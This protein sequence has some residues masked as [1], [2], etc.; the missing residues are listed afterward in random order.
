MLP[1]RW[2]LPPFDMP[3]PLNLSESYAYHSRASRVIAGGVNSNVRLPGHGA[4]LCFAKAQGAHLTDLDGNDYIDYALGMGPAILGHAPEAVIDAVAKSLQGGQLYA[5]QSKAE[6]ELGNRLRQYIPGAELV[7]IGMTGSE[8]VQVALRVARAATGRDKFVKF[9]GHYH[10]WLDNVL[11]NE[12]TF[13]VIEPHT[14]SAQA[15]SRGQP[16]GSLADTAVLPWNDLQTLTGYLDRHAGETA[17]VVME[18][19]MCNTSVIPPAPGYLEGVRKLCSSHGI[20][21]I[22]DEV[23]TGFRLELAGAQKTFGVT[24]DLGIFAKAL[25]GGVP[26]AALTGQASL[27]SLIGSGTV[28]HSG[29]YNSNLIAVSA[30]IATIDALAKD[31]GAVYAKI[32]AT[33]QALMEGIRSMAR[34]VGAGLI[35]QG[36]P[37]VFNTCF[38]DGQTINSLEDYRRCDV[39]RQQ[40]FLNALLERGVRPTGRGTWFVSAAHSEVDVEATLAAVQGALKACE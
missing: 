17:A 35:V 5:G 30:A 31:N 40:R 11:T 36:Y 12:Y 6:L 21:L 19:V 16:P 18:L 32:A 3:K 23:V 27:M 14:R 33:G 1:Y 34:G 13:S 26:V 25:G 24:G 7:R 4:A 29:T 8:M 39:S 10:G 20:V 37:S 38:G 2:S 9:S 15:A 28:N 22:A